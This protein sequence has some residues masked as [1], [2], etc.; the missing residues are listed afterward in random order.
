MPR[1]VCDSACVCLQA[2]P[3]TFCF[4]DVHK[5]HGLS[6][7]AARGG[8][9]HALERQRSPCGLFI[10]CHVEC[11]FSE[12]LFTAARVHVFKYQRYLCHS[13][14]LSSC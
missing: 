11:S 7:R 14:V 8:T 1:C 10:K 2:F 3:F 12:L 6:K 13:L 5:A 4:S 9:A